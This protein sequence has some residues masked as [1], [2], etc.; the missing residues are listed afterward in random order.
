V[1]AQFAHP[2]PILVA[3][4][5]PQVLADDAEAMEIALALAPPV[6]ELDAQ[7]ERPLRLAQEVVLVEAEQLVELLDGGDGRLAHPDRADR[8]GLD[9]DDLVQPLEQARAQ[10]RRHPSGRP[11]AGDQYLLERLQP[12]ASR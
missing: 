3:A 7:L 1:R 5:P 9:E 11:A 8:L 10:R 4:Q 12:P 2:Q 6:P